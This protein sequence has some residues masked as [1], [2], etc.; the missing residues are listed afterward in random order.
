MP[1]RRSSRRE[2]RRL[3]CSLLLALAAALTLTA[4]AQPPRHVTRMPSAAP[5]TASF[6]RVIFPGHRV[7]AYYGAA[8]VP[9]MGILGSASPH[10]ILPK[11]LRQADA[12]AR[13]GEPVIPAF[14]LIAVVAQRAPGNADAY[15]AP[16][17]SGTV[18]RY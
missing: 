9:A 6:P 8:D 5:A 3:K 17:D 4:C 18:Q 10:H 15:S 12:Y 14:E 16:V 11:L 2:P 13:Y 7:V 1:R